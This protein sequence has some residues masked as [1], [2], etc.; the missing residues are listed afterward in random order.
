LV[1]ERHFVANGG[2]D[3][4]F[5]KDVAGHRRTGKE[6]RAA[7]F[8]MKGRAPE[9]DRDSRAQALGAKTLR[10]ATA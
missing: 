10:A 1:V 8:G 3:V 9:R 4:V 6:P 7:R 2:V 5:I